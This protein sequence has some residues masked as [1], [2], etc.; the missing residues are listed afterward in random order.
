MGYW[1]LLIL[2]PATKEAHRDKAEN[3]LRLEQVGCGVNGS[4]G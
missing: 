1:N 2:Y 4:G 3:F